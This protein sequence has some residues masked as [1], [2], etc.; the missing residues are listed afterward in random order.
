MDTATQQA[1][2]RIGNWRFRRQLNQLQSAD[3][4]VH[5]EPKVGALFGLLADHPGQAMHRD[6]LLEAIWP[7][8]VVGDETLSNAVAKLRRALGDDPRHPG[9]IETLPKIG[10]RL[11]ATVSEVDD[12]PGEIAAK[13]GWKSARAR[14]LLMPAIAL[15]I[16]AASWALAQWFLAV[17]PE[18][19][20][21]AQVPTLLV[22]PFRAIDESNRNDAFVAGMAA[23]IVTD[24]SRLASLQVIAGSNR[25]TGVAPIQAARDTRADFVLDGSMRRDG[26]RIRVNVQLVEVE[27]GVQVWGERFDRQLEDVFIVQDE[28][29]RQIVAALSIRLSS[30]E[31]SAI[32][33][34]VSTRVRAYEIYMEGLRRFSTETREG[35]DFAQAAWEQ[36]LAIDP[37][38]ARA[39]GSLAVLHT[40]NYRRGWTDDP[41]EALE[42]ALFL[43][44]RAKE[45]GPRVPQV[46]WSLGYVHLYRRE[47]DQALDAARTAVTIAPGYSAGYGLLAVIHNEMGNWRQAIAA[48]ERA[49]RLEPYAGFHI[50]Y[51]LGRAHYL[52]GHYDRAVENLNEALEID[53][54]GEMARLFLI[55]SLAGQGRIDDAEWEVEMLLVEKPEIS[56]HVIERTFAQREDLMKKFLADLR[57]AGVPD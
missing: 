14:K 47:Y 57:A 23:D 36:A 30:A 28:I 4:V 52:A 11:I 37:R 21:V 17:P 15:A 2:V 10:Y 39:Y 1:D 43:A 46:Y 48:I 40:R 41:G 51:N 35:V 26:E 13:P 34:I 16:V 29:A 22:L 27:S 42:Q 6:R 44:N 7:D 56:L 19:S 55:A 9:Y 49:R 25:V 38:F 54:L 50:P 8:V 18:S 53:N 45:L 5:L 31:R 33:E 3:E 32:G 24:L 20:G 12:A